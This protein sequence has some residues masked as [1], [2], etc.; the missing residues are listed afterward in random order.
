MKFQGNKYSYIVEFLQNFLGKR[1]LQIH[2]GKHHGK[3]VSSSV[4]S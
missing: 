4:F 2:H 3:H 1:E